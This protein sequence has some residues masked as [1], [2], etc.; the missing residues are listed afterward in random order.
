[1]EPKFNDT[2]VS[3][4]RAPESE[5]TQQFR[6]DI[7]DDVGRYVRQAVNLA[8]GHPVDGNAK[9]AARKNLA[10]MAWTF[11]CENTQN[12]YSTIT[13]VLAEE[14]FAAWGK[15]ARPGLDAARQRESGNLLINVLSLALHTAGQIHRSRGGAESSPQA[16]TPDG[17]V[18]DV[19]DAVGPVL[20]G[21]EA[22]E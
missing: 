8:N 1:M 15:L 14:F 21:P 7:R 2:P 18:E 17:I 3:R 22:G 5:R 4:A 6:R 10:Q 19:T 9:E 13:Q 16:A 12:H 11:T 20:K